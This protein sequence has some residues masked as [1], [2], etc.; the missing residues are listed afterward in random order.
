MELPVSEQFQLSHLRIPAVA[1]RAEQPAQNEIFTAN[2]IIVIENR[3]QYVWDK[4]GEAVP[5]SPAAAP[6]PPDITARRFKYGD[7]NWY[8][9]SEY[10]QVS[11][12]TLS[13]FPV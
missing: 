7:G 10:H 9:I 12:A 5:N 13:Q 11:L 8:P 1:L 4:D 3:L 2:V 6:Q